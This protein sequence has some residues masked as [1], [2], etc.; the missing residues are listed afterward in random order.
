M[1]LERQEAVNLEAVSMILIAFLMD[2][3]IGAVVAVGFRKLF[4]EKWP[5]APWVM[6][7]VAFLFLGSVGAMTARLAAYLAMFFFLACAALRAR[8]PKFS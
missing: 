2:L 4:G 5:R 8:F 6:A 7:A 3:F 1:G